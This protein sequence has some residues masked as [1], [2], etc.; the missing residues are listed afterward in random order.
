M[1][2]YK[3]IVLHHFGII[4][5]Y[6]I[7]RPLIS[8]TTVSKVYYGAVQHAVNSTQVIK[9]NVTVGMSNTERHKYS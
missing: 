8:V 2:K 4:H 1:R 3:F 9:C 5:F 7:K 6:Q